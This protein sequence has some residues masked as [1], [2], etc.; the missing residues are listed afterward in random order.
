MLQ[1]I[2]GLG[3]SVDVNMV[4]RRVVE[5]EIQ[6]IAQLRQVVVESGDPTAV[7]DL[8]VSI[9]K[10]RTAIRLFWPILNQ[11]L[12]SLDLQLREVFHR[13]GELRNLDVAILACC[14]FS[15]DV[16]EDLVERLVQMRTLTKPKL[17]TLLTGPCVVDVLIRIENPV[18]IVPQQNVWN[19]DTHPIRLAHRK[20]V[21]S[22]RRVSHLWDLVEVHRLR[23]RI[24]RLRYAVEFFAPEMG[25]S[26]KAYAKRLEAMQNLLGKTMDQVSLS[27]F[28]ER[29]D[30][31]SRGE[32]REC[33]NQASKMAKKATHNRKELLKFKREISGREWK[34]LKSATRA[35]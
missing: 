14:D 32:T 16:R 2:S 34:V 1:T 6:R 24:K 19:N 29:L 3:I 30:H 33:R 17:V 7:H 27:S 21:K 12:R 25:K 20:T 23:R 15:D 5:G 10:L 9:R 22:L 13:L 11:E 18:A 35:A 26:A 31:L 4:C 8:R 28:F